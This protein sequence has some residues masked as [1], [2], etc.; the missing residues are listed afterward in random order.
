[1]QSYTKGLYILANHNILPVVED[2]RA[3]PT[4]SVS[5]Y[6][7]AQVLLAI[8]G[9]GMPRRNVAYSA[10]IFAPV[11]REATLAPVA[12]ATTPRT[13]RKIAVRLVVRSAGAT[14]VSGLSG[15][16]PYMLDRE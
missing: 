12:S 7:P 4:V 13:H 3:A 15:V 14:T 10:S 5:T 9:V 2:F 6:K 16:A 8:N 11:E 1:M